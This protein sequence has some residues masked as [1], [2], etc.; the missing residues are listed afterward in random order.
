MCGSLSG[1]GVIKKRERKKLIKIDDIFEASAG[2]AERNNNPFFCSAARRACVLEMWSSIY[3]LSQQRRKIDFLE[4][5]AFDVF[6]KKN[7]KNR[8]SLTH[9]QH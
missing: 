8:T 2:S 3:R 7:D 1:I 9:A 5:F 6:F 4:S